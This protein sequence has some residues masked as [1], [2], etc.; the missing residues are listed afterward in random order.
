MLHPR[1]FGKLIR[2]QEPHLDLIQSL[3]NE[4]GAVHIRR[5]AV[6]L[7]VYI[8]LMG[9]MIYLPMLQ[10]RLTCHLLGVT[11]FFHFH[12]WYVLPEIQIPLEI[13]V[14]HI[15]FLSVLDKH[16]D[17]IGHGQHVVLV[18]LADKLGLTRFLI[19]LSTLGRR[20]SCCFIF[21]EQYFAASVIAS[22]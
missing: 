1:I 14:G 2:P 20:V 4:G 12:Y 17:V 11:P 7:L 6:S 15:V 21:A 18:Y 16:K 19:P 5:I 8:L 22:L 10:L 9:V 3:I 13:M